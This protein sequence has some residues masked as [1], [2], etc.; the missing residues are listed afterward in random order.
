VEDVNRQWLTTADLAQMLEMSES[1]I[2]RW[3]RQRKLP[4]FLSPGGQYRFDADEIQSLIEQR[5]VRYSRQM[6]GRYDD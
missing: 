5:R 3:A 4:H 6:A 2:R 1:T